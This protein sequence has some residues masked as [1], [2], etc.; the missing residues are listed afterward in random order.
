[1]LEGGDFRIKLEIPFEQTEGFLEFPPGGVNGTEGFNLTEVTEESEKD[2][3][4][5]G[6]IEIGPAIFIVLTSFSGSLET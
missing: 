5:V 4:E 2:L 6:E 3:A 1:L